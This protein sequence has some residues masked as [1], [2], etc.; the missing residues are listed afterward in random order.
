MNP[1]TERRKRFAR[2][3]VSQLP[4]TLNHRHI[5]IL[6][7]RHG[8]LFFGVLLAMLIGSVNYNNN[9]GFLLVFLLGSMALIALFHTH[10][11]LAGLRI[12]SAAARPVFAGETAVFEF[13]VAGQQ[14]S[15]KALVFLLEKD[16]KRTVEVPAGKE[17]RVPVKTVAPRRGMFT[18]GP[19]TVTTRFPLGLFYAWSRLDLA[20]SCL[21]YPRPLAGPFHL[22]KQT[23]AGDGDEGIGDRHGADD[24]LGLKIYQAGDPVRQISWKAFSRG[25][26]LFIKEFAGHGRRVVVFDYE[27]I[28]GADTEEKLSRL[29]DLIRKAALANFSYGLRLPETF[30]EP[31]RGEQHQHHCLKALALFGTGSVRQ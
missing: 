15:R 19:I 8:L 30:L 29:C 31:D 6:P 21:V 1:P 11:N 5:Y 3:T 22:P 24:F 14:L 12:L 26:G 25:Q 4:V 13:L 9:L 17:M 16:R 28:P 2:K 18:P 7:T 23:R 20:L 27:T 10:R